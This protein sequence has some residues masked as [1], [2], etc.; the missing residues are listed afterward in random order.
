MR[1]FLYILCVALPM[2]IGLSS[3]VDDND[4]CSALMPEQEG[5]VH[6]RFTIMTRNDVKGTRN[7]KT[8]LSRVADIEGDQEGSGVENQ[9]NI[10]GNDIHYYLF[11]GNRRFLQDFTPVAKTL[12]ESKDYKVYT[13]TANIE[14]D[15]FDNNIEGTVNFYILALANYSGW[16]V[17]M[18]TI[19]KGSTIEQLFSDGLAMTVLPRS[20]VLLRTDEWWHLNPCGHYFP[21][22]GL[23]K[24]SVPGSMLYSSSESMPYDLSR[25][26]GKDLNMLRALA[27]I[28]VIDKINVNGVYDVS[29]DGIYF[30]D[31][32]SEDP[33][34]KNSWLRVEKA[35]INGIMNR[36]TLLP[37][38]TEWTNADADETQ[39]VNLPTIL[40]NF[41]YN[42]PPVLAD[43]GDLGNT[44]GFKSSVIN[45][46]PDRYATELREDKC[47][48]FSGYVFEY[49]KLA[50]QLTDI[51]SAQ[52]PYMI[53]TTR[54][55][56]SKLEDGTIRTDA[57]SMVLPVRLANYTN[58]TATS[59]DNLNYLLR[60]HIYRYEVTGIAQDIQVNWTVCNMDTGEAVIE[61]N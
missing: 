46:F 36:G 42:V 61:F 8:P 23:Q 49:S 24:F 51:P 16:G 33:A 3:C 44:E 58:G 50:N 29:T 15:Y 12:S 56:T 13:V 11:D 47:P 40:S 9:L 1:K 21:M 22:A 18:P 28:E 31:G 34:G 57:E 38:I 48:V 55:H 54:G 27:K 43:D 37:D 4:A 45:F 60:N 5:K 20:N 10:E 35:E 25:A 17:K 39:Q 41:I 14:E 53:I 52:Q 19:E 26:T 59:A 2:V 6:L 7:S 32:T 30:H